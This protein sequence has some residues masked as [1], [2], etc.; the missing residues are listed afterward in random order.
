[1][2]TKEPG[3]RAPTP[4]HQDQPYYNV[5]GKQNCSMWIP[6]DPVRRHSTLEFVAGSHRGPWLMPRSFMDH[7]A[8][9]F[10][11]GSLAELPDIEGTRAQQPI[12]GW[13][14][15]PGDVVCFHMLALHA[16]GGVD[17]DR[18]RR[19]F[20][21]RFLGDDMRHA[22]RRWATSP[23]FPGLAER[24]A[25]RRAD[26]RPAVPVAVEA[27]RMTLQRWCAAT[28]SSRSPGAT[29]AGTRA[30]CWP[31][32]ARDDWQLRI[33]V[34]DIDRDGPFS[35]FPGVRPLVRGGRRR[36]RAP[37]AAR[38]R[39][40]DRHRQRA[41]A[42][43]RRGRA[44]LRPARRADARPEPDGAARRRPRRDATR[45]NAGADFQ[46]R[47]ALRALFCADAVT[48]QIDGSDARVLAAVHAAVVRRRRPRAAGGCAARCDRPRAWWLELR[49]D[50]TPHDDTSGATPAWPRWPAAAPWGWIE[51]GALLVDGDTAALG[52]RRRRPARR[53]AGRRRDRPRRRAGHARAWS[54]ATPTWSTAASA[55][56]NSSCGCK[57]PATSRSPAPA[58]ASAPPWRPPA[59]PATSSCCAS[60]ARARADADGRGRDHAGDQVRLRP[61]RRARGALPA[62]GAPAGP[63]AAADGAHHL[64]VGACAA[65]G[66]RRPRRR[67]HR[68]RLRLAAGSCRPKAWSMRSMPSA[69]TS[70]SRPAQT[71]RV[72]EAARRLGLPV[73]LHAEQLSDQRRRGA[74]RVASAR[75][76][77]TTWNTCRT[78]ASRAMAAAG[79]VAVL[80]PG[81][82]YFLRETKLPPVAGAARRRRAD[83]H[84]QR[85]QPRLVAGPVAAA[86]AEHGLH[87][88]PHDAR[89][90]AARRH[91]AWRTRARP[92]R[93]RHAGSRPARRLRRLGPGAPERAGL[94]V[95]PQPLPA[96]R[97]RRRRDP[98][99]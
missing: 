94:L 29:A 64:P 55:R 78:T 98:R 15:E 44:G 49:A 10:P 40:V 37:A 23:D 48:L 19:V 45:A 33:S 50:A 68:R 28:R 42:L 5:E 18:R 38:R 89:R 81:A 84:G 27:K 54:T 96:R 63:R 99:A 57:A 80:L 79:T 43:S 77:A 41:A 52:R 66:V 2:L 26:G 91:R 25:G 14:L 6:V 16:A 13:A 21:V 47:A 62:R 24:A 39:A 60:A 85:P 12:L 59:R 72:F 3:T 70:P 75:C 31:G 4:W 35:A 95:R 20:S 9:W 69:N 1:M 74:G 11:E 7:Q 76:P 53:P 8:K 30:S 86:D 97:R 32:R 67:L 90:S 61:E 51:R 71:R 93:P 56:A 17:G 36:G 87:P 73:K 34:A 46:P 88:V 82:F 92:A 58:A 65:A 22:P 83:R